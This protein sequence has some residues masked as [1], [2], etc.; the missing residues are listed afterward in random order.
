MK[1]S[2]PLASLF[3][4]SSSLLLAAAGSKTYADYLAAQKRAIS[5]EVVGDKVL[6]TFAQSLYGKKCPKLY[7]RRRNDLPGTD[8]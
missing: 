1:K 5:R 7:D 4:L 2:I 3:A 6:T 8:A